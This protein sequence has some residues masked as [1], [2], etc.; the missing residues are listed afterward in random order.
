MNQNKNKIYSSN[1]FEAAQADI[2]QLHLARSQK[3]FVSLSVLML[4]KWRND[5]EIE[6]ANWFEASYLKDPYNRWS[7]TSSD[8]AGI[9]PNQNP[10]DS[11]HRGQKRDQGRQVGK[12]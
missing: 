9:S 3:Q 5:K 12:L 2:S 8:I 10:I 4:N 7:V 6:L 11:F 1:Y